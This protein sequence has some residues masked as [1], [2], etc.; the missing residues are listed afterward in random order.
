MTALNSA[1]MPACSCSRQSFHV[2]GLLPSAPPYWVVLLQGLF[3]LKPQP[4]QV[5]GDHSPLLRAGGAAPGLGQAKEYKQNP[6]ANWLSCFPSSWPAGRPSSAGTCHPA[7]A[8][9]PLASS[10]SSAHSA[11]G[12]WL[13]QRPSLSEL[14]SGFIFGRSCNLSPYLLPS[15]REGVGPLG[16]AGDQAVAPAP[17]VWTSLGLQGRGP[18]KTPDPSDASQPDASALLPPPSV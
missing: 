1:P 14:S 16:S 17:G 7:L 15:F 8:G 10:L 13:L 9:I 5:P 2:P 12:L 11:F 6:V 18:S 4:D 3:V